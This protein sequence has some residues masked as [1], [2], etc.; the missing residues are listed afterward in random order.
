MASIPVCSH[1]L[2][3]SCSFGPRCKKLHP[4]RATIVKETVALVGAAA[5]PGP[6]ALTGAPPPAR[7]PPTIECVLCFDTTGSMY[8][9]LEDVRRQLGDIIKKLVGK[10][11]KHGH[12]LRL[13]VIAHGDYCDKKSSYVDKFLPLLDTQDNPAAVKKL[14]DFV[15]GVGPTG[16]GD[17]PECYELA[18]HR[19]WKDMGWG[20]RSTR[21]LVMVG[22][23]TPHPVGYTCNGYENRL[24]WRKELDSLKHKNI[25]CYAVQAPRPGS[26]GAPEGPGAWACAKCTTYN[27]GPA[28]AA[29]AACIEC[30]T[31][32]P[33]APE[34]TATGFWQAVADGGGAGG[35][36]FAV[37]DL[38]TVRGLILG[39]VVKDMGRA[40]YG[41]LE[42]EM[43]DEGAMTAELEGVY[44]V[45]RRT[46]TTT[47]VVLCRPSGGGGGG[48]LPSGV[49]GGAAAKVAKAL[50]AAGRVLDLDR[51][52]LA[53]C[54]HFLAGSCKFGDACKKP[55][56]IPK[57]HPKA[58]L[59]GAAAV[60][61]KPERTVDCNRGPGCSFLRNGSCTFR[62]APAEV[63]AARRAK[64]AKP[65]TP[66]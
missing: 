36:R 63:A 46:V 12:R 52:A 54:S 22:D 45:M 34:P 57:P 55:H 58:P 29:A 9:Y 14:L 59:A 8:K 62:H 3:G 2:N 37:T 21:T 10:A 1:Y 47:E 6:K 51:D 19:A 23:A 7:E 11:N 41:E 32:K 60:T 39:A 26:G 40:A 50:P 35:Q 61:S 65:G 64:A 56:P 15:A 4:P 28:A 33:E 49:S 44:A 48:Y 27:V 43:R 18:L 42:K 13:G 20:P 17:D 5:S 66:A 53:P 24:D 31:A 38:A 16:G 30:R 25:K